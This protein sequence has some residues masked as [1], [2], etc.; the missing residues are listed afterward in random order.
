M[1][2]LLHQTLKNYQ[3]FAGNRINNEKLDQVAEEI[4]QKYNFDHI[5]VTKSE[6]NV[7]LFQKAR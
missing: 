6:K 7:K 4:R 1:Q 2:T 5:L 3:S